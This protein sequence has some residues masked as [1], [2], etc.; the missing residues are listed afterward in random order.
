MQLYLF[1]FSNK[2]KHVGLIGEAHALQSY[3]F[4]LIE[5]FL[6]GLICQT[7]LMYL[8][9]QLKFLKKR[10]DFVLEKSRMHVGLQW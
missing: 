6:W 8:D 5:L 3:V 9:E 2:R 7:M 1:T 4:L 10:L